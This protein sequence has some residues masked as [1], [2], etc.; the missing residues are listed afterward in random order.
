MIGVVGL[1]DMGA[2]VAHRIQHS[3]FAVTGIE[4]DARRRESWAARTG[5]AV[6]THPGE[7]QEA[8]AFV[9]LVRTS[10]QALDVLGTLRSEH[11]SG[12]CYVATTMSPA[13]AKQLG[14]A[15][16]HRMRVVE[17]PLSGGADA[18]L[19]GELTAMAAGPLHE[20]DATLLTST[21]IGRI[22]R[23]DRYGQPTLA[24]LLNNVTGAFNAAAMAAMLKLGS[25]AG[26]PSPQL[27]ELIQHS[28]G[29]SWMAGA[30]PRLRE[31]LLTKDV[32]LL[33][34]E[35]GELPILDL[36]DQVSLGATLRAAMSSLAGHDIEPD[37]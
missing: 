24:K 22:F 14:T 33:Q 3:G 1:G 20:P 2:A 15:G 10:E 32:G 13:A 29:A 8:S 17:L 26:I 11:F 36:N 5:A 4:P 37:A 34:A 7:C 23:F 12:C 27:H 21:F 9:V 18:A 25:Q 28:S 6:A 19:S 35:L 30:L 31:Q 16:D